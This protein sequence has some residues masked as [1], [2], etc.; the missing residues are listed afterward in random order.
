MEHGSRAHPHILRLHLRPHVERSLPHRCE[1]HCPR[2][3]SI[4][5]SDPLALRTV[6]ALVNTDTLDTLQ[7]YVY[8]AA[9][10]GSAWM[11]YVFHNLCD[12]SDPDCGEFSTSPSNLRDLLSWLDAKGVAVRRV[13]DVVP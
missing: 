4:P 1:T 11:V 3:E 8:D 6:P 7:W 10:L 12:A 9:A 2:G 13:R 5:P